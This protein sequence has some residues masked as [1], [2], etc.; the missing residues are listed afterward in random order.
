MHITWI[1]DD[2]TEEVRAE[3]V[4]KH[5]N[6][7]TANANWMIFVIVFMCFPFINYG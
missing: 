3:T 5:A 2:E 7:N 1:R 6:A 4:S